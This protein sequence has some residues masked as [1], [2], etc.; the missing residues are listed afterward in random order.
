MSFSSKL[1]VMSNIYLEDYT[2]TTD[3]S[4]LKAHLINTNL[5][6]NRHFL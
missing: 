4:I 2:I 3:E 5:L 6:Q 1:G